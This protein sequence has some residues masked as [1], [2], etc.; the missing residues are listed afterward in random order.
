M[1]IISPACDP[2]KPTKAIVAVV[3]RGI[4]NRYGKTTWRVTRDWVMTQIDNWRYDQVD[5]DGYAVHD[6]D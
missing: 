1:D 6:S 5:M 2:S 3:A 4:M